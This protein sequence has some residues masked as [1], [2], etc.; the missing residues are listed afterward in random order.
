MKIKKSKYSL[1]VELH[2]NFNL[3]AVRDIE[4]LMSKRQELHVDLSKSR[5]VD[6]HAVIFLHQLMVRN[7]KVRLRN[8]PRIFYELLHILGLHNVW[9]LKKIIEP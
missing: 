5:F 2:G 8:P 6:S 1:R 4:S 7:A 3:Q 9:E